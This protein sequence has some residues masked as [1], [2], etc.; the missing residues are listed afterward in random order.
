MEK[1]METHFA[2]PER[3]DRETVG[4]MSKLL[5]AEAMS[6]WF[7]ALPVSILV[8][9]R[10]RQI[11]YF[12]K[13]FH[14]LS[15]RIN[16]EEIVG[17][18]PGE[19]LGCVN[20]ELMEGGCGCS[21]LCSVCGAAIAILNSLRG[22][23][24]CQECNLVRND[25]GSESVLDLQVFTR[26]VEIAGQAL[27]LFTAMDISHEKRL[28]YMERKFF[29]DMV[30][31][32][33]GM[34]QLA[35]LSEEDADSR[36]GYMEIMGDCSRH[37]LQEVLFLRDVT[38][39]EIGRLSAHYQRVFLPAIIDDVV[40]DYAD[41]PESRRVRVD[42]AGVGGE[43]VTDPRLLRHVLGCIYLN[44]LESGEGAKT[45]TIES[46]EN[47]GFMEVKFTNPGRIPESIR[48]QLFKR[49][50]STKDRSRGL[51]LY[52]SRMLARDYLQGDV[53]HD[54]EGG[55]TTFT[56]SLPLDLAPGWVE[57]RKK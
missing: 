29:H 56:V 17:L 5:R 26:P 40:G 20:A 39:A 2:A 57:P 47:G 50:V 38:A 21:E 18:R 19:A 13:S 10:D 35:S 31:A 15:K 36:D 6:S 48:K 27:T 37:I 16:P 12:N 14:E 42:M 51:G 43:A 44:A 3:Q 11:V 49:Y 24:D 8:L 33:G 34:A 30:N 46:R 1:R 52:V 4:S 54:Y 32:A 41:R 55:L 9:N 22:E 53:R 25:E 23:S 28:S 7:D 45:I